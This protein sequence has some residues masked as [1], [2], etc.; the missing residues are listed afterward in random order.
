[1]P[2]LTEHGRHRK[3]S[4]GLGGR[5]REGQVE[6]R[7][8]RGHG[9]WQMSWGGRSLRLI[10]RSRRVVPSRAASSLGLKSHITLVKRARLIKQEVALSP[11]P[12]AFGFLDA[13]SSGAFHFSSPRQNNKRR[14][15]KASYDLPSLRRSFPFPKDPDSTS[16]QTLSQGNGWL[17][18]NF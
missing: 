15:R 5:G 9:F 3:Q 7:W 16:S 6:G 2:T 17:V 14:W 13:I 1:M 12:A 11:P 8:G 10:W 4:W 18:M